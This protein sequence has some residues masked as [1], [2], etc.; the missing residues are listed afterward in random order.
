MAA[1]HLGK[2]IDI[3]GGGI[4]LQFPHHENEIAQS[5]CAHGQQMARYWM[6][7]GF[8]DMGGEKMSKSLGNVVLVHEL[9]EAWP[10]EVLRFAMLSGHYRAPLDWTEDLLKQAKTTLDRIYG[11]LRRVW[12]AEGGKARDKGVLRALQDDLNTPVA[13]AELSR[14][15][16][17]ANTAADQKDDAAM[18]EARADLLA[19]GELLGLLTLTPKAWEQGGDDDGN[20]RIDALVQARIDARAAKNWA[21]ADRIR[22]QLAAEGIEIMDGAGGSTWRRV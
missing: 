2:T 7:N 11:A 6:H 20:A 9:L 17:E 21:E 14:L 10:G 3:H 12:D 4:D 15:A 16:G 18:A 5:E 13:L 22:D 1:K 8:L 19:A